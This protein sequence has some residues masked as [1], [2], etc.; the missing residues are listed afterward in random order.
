MINKTSMAL[1]KKLFDLY[2]TIEVVPFVEKSAYGYSDTKLCC[3]ESVTYIKLFINTERGKKSCYKNGRTDRAFAE[4]EP[5][6]IPLKFLENKKGPRDDTIM[7]CRFIVTEK[8]KENKIPYNY[9]RKLS[10]P[11]FYNIIKAEELSVLLVNR[12][13]V[14]KCL[15]LNI[16]KSINIFNELR[17][18]SPYCRCCQRRFTDDFDKIELEEK[19]KSNKE[20]IVEAHK[21]HNQKIFNT[22]TVDGCHSCVAKF[23]GDDCIICG[24]DMYGCGDSVC[25]WRVSSSHC[26]C[27]K[28]V[29]LLWSWD[30]SEIDWVNDISLYS[31]IPVGGGVGPS[32]DM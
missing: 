8:L 15:P 3:G 17:D 2:Y 29:N 4:Y 1:A 24:R 10:Y 32:R 18:I 21:N 23:R 28:N 31:K 7:L 30:N 11:E 26:S 19:A 25:I 27:G 20:I 6:R 13:A 14:E 12:Y 22:Y 9:S 5:I 16:E